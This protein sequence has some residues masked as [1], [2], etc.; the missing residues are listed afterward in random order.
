[1]CGLDRSPGDGLRLRPG[2]LPGR[3]DATACAWTPD[4][5]LDDGGG[6]VAAPV[7]WAA[8]DCP[9]GWAVD[10]LGRPMVLGT[11]TASVRRRPTVGERC[12]VTG[13]ALGSEGRRSMTATTLYDADGE[14]LARAAHVWV[15]ID[16][17]AFSAL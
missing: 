1:V 4:A 2:P 10:L 8:M 7:V 14:E 16:P 17:A 12:V 3:D 15:A 5:S 13:T 9:G 11:M 6:S